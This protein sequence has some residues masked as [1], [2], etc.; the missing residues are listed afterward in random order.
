M[1]SAGLE[2]PTRLAKACKVS[3][4]TVVNWLAMD[5]AELSGEMLYTV[6]KCLKVRL[7]WLVAEEGG[8]PGTEAMDRAIA[9]LSRL[10][11]EQAEE[12]LA[13]GENMAA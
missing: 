5:R 4:Q 1:L 10:D 7:I 2:T 12:W 9:I 11:S 8:V 6:A 13:I 3:R